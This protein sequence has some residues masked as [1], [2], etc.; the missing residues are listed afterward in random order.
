MS[1]KT[2]IA[3]AFFDHPS[4][5]GVIDLYEDLQNDQVI[6]RGRLK[7]DIFTNSY[8]GFHVHEAGDLSDSCMGACAHFNPHNKNH[9]GP[10]S[11]TRHV[12]DLG[13]IYFDK[14]GI[15]NVN[16][17]DAFVKLRG[18]KSNVVGRSLIIHEDPDDLGLGGHNDS[19]TT[20]HAGGRVTCAVIGYSKKMFKK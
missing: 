13:N 7:S 10:N 4:I 2:I 9:G 17:K 16:M 12:G 14:R 1:K 5:K 20:G 11:R 15:A 8:H 19:L 3:T 6:I 18:T